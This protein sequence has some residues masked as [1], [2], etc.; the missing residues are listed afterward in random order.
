MEKNIN[1]KIKTT[2]KGTLLLTGL[3]MIA[4]V[5]TQAKSAD[6]PPI[7]VQYEQRRYVSVEHANVG[8]EYWY[9]EDGYKGY[10]KRSLRPSY[11][12]DGVL[13]YI[14]SGTIYKFTGGGPGPGGGYRY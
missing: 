7:E 10:L 8:A 1:K 6:K 3:L 4:P 12:K 5:L 9:E 11:E 14:Y 2:I 13:Y